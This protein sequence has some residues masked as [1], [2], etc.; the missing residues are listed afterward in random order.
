MRCECYSLSA[1]NRTSQPLSNTTFNQSEESAPQM[2]VARHTHVS[3]H[4]CLL[5][6]HT[7]AL[8]T[9]V[10]SG[11]IC[12]EHAVLLPSVYGVSAVCR[13]PSS[14][15]D[16]FPGVQQL[17]GKNMSSRC[18]CNRSII[19][20]IKLIANCENSAEAQRQGIPCI[21]LAAGRQKVQPCTAAHDGFDTDHIAAH[22]AVTQQPQSSCKAWQHA[23]HV[24]HSETSK[25]CAK[26]HAQHHSQVLLHGMLSMRIKNII[27]VTDRMQARELP[28]MLCT[29]SIE[30]LQILY[31]G[32][33]DQDVGLQVEAYM[34]FAGVLR[35]MK[36]AQRV[37]QATN[38]AYAGS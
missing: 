34:A 19:A 25:I 23:R 21:V 22:A 6:V 20:P 27:H 5:C 35:Q 24:L 18:L 37:S 9:D 2:G 32:C 33:R 10:S 14:N 30:Q 11:N 4:R 3:M 8:C 31:T 38:S 13:Q 29:S 36:C 16:S 1:S 12:D 7:P 15:P 17:S 26:R 28:T